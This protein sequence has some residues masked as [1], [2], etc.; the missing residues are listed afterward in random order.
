ML[1]KLLLDTEGRPAQAARAFAQCL[2][3][4]PPQAIAEDALF[5]LVQAQDRSGD[6]EAARV[7]AE[8]YR[9]RYPAG[10][11]LR[12]LRSWLAP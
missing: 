1:G 2:S 4:S 6:T 3:L 12:D 8:E 5:R 9:R 10:R 11:H 7:T